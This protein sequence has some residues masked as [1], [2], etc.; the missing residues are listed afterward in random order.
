MP[1]DLPPPAIIIEATAFS[2][3]PVID[4][5]SPGTEGNRYGFE[6]GTVLRLEEGVLHL[7]TAERSGDPMIVK[8]R[9]AHWQSQDGLAW[10]RLSTLY[11]SSG[12]FTG[13]DPRAALW[14]PM[15]VYHETQNRWTLFYVAYRAK[16][17]TP[18]AWYENHEGRIWYAESTVQG[19]GG[20]GGPYQDVGVILQPDA[21]SQAWEGLQGVDSFFPFQAGGRWLGFYGSAQTQTVPCPFWGT[22]L[23]EAPALEGPW[24]RKQDGNPVKM[25]PVFAENPIVSRMGALHVALVDGGPNGKFGYATSRDGVTWSRADFIDLA[26]VGTPWWEVMRTPLCLLPEADGSWTMFF[27]A[28]RSRPGDQAFGAIGRAKVRVTTRT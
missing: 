1:L 12:D 2:P 19:R 7:V 24:R 18:T 28:W 8:M 17:N 3:A 5:G 22:G 16:P 21:E 26:K 20:L 6:G 14:G 15:P 10:E 27:T 13:A 25:D 11:E 4:A 9:L 23:A